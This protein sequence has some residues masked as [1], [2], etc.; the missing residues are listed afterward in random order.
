MDFQQ[1]EKDFFSKPFPDSGLNGNVYETNGTH[2]S[3]FNKKE[4]KDDSDDDIGPE[5]DVDAVDDVLV[6]PTKNKNGFESDG[7]QKQ[8]TED[9]IMPRLI[10]FSSN[11]D[12]LAM[13]DNI[14]N[15]TNENSGVDGAHSNDYS[16]DMNPFNNNP[17]VK[18][19]ENLIG[20][21]DKYN[22]E[23]KLNKE[24]VDNLVNTNLIDRS[25]D[26]NIFEGASEN[27]FDKDPL[28]LG[29]DESNEKNISD[30]NRS[31]DLF[32]CDN[33]M[34][35]N[36]N[37]AENKPDIGVAENFEVLKEPENNVSNE[38]NP[39]LNN[40][41]NTMDNFTFQTNEP[42]LVFDQSEVRF[43]FFFFMFL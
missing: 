19:S 15:F 3:N 23:V 40:I 6:S 32:E 26:K 28:N 10:D 22:E 1:A 12:T 17:F 11:K 9:G 36:I 7:H 25:N 5:T 38:N 29:K 21:S 30:F 2:N 34:F 43:L 20:A 27:H 13:M 42:Q 41:L 37:T 16:V 14:L 33:D 4:N 31:E 8:Q 35:V 18:E 24:E 39:I